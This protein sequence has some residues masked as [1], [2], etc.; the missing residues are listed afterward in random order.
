[1]KQHQEVCHCYARA[2]EADR[3]SGDRRTLAATLGNLGNICAVSGRRAQAQD[4]YLEVLELQKILGD[5]RG[6]STTL[7]NLGNLY[8]D[9]GEWI[10][11]KVRNRNGRRN[12][13]PPSSRLLK[14]V[15]NNGFG[16][17]QN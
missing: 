8:A 16:P 15:F 3:Q 10:Q 14:R 12:L 2:L 4:Y 7:A 5:E 17:S 6:I 1:M 9:A 13:P 11:T